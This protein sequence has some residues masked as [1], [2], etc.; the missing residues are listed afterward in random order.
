MMYINTTQHYTVY[1]TNSQGTVFLCACL[2]F[3][4]SSLPHGNG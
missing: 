3:C 4:C 1:N 2:T